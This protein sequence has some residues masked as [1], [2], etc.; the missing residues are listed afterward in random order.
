[1]YFHPTNG[2]QSIFSLSD[3]LQQ[4]FSI[5]YNLMS[6]E[7]SVALALLIRKMYHTGNRFRGFAVY[8]QKTR[9]YI[10]WS[11]RNALDVGLPLVSSLTQR[12]RCHQKFKNPRTAYQ[13]HWTICREWSVKGVLRAEPLT[14][15]TT[16]TT[17]KVSLTM[18]SFRG[19]C[20]PLPPNGLCCHRQPPQQQKYR[21]IDDSVRGYQSVSDVMYVVCLSS[22]GL[23]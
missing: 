11:M 9:S 20:F 19:W 22:F 21:L 2:L 12:R 8:T 6:S 17:H 5:S 4:A 16:C 1:M 3:G 15:H 18:N 10:W 23:K 7:Y 14:W 13:R